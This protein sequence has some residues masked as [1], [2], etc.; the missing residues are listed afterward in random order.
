MYIITPQLKNQD[1]PL[2]WVV[3]TDD[4]CQ[5]IMLLESTEQIESFSVKDSMGT[6]ISD[7]A[8]YFGMAR[9]TKG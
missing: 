1:F 2:S 9:L 4:M 7:V 3:G 6:P 8:N 5:T